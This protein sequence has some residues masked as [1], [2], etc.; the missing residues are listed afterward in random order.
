MLRKL[1]LFCAVLAFTGCNRNKQDSGQPAQQNRADANSL[2]VQ[3]FDKKAFD[4]KILGLSTRE[5]RE[6][7]GAPYETVRVPGMGFCWRYNFPEPTKPKQGSCVFVSIEND[8]A[9]ATY[10]N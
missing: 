8:R 5:I 9:I 4:E 7:L 3:P 2:L 1:L 6:Q 10:V